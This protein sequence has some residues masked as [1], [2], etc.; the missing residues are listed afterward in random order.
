MALRTEWGPA[1]ELPPHRFTT[2]E[3][4]RMHEAGVLDEDDRVE[5][6]E[7][8]VLAMS[9]IGSRHARCTV[10]LDDG[11]RESLPRGAYTIRVRMPISI[12][13]YDEPE[14]DVAVVWRREDLYED[15]HPG[16]DDTLL[17]VEVSDVTYRRDR[18]TKL[19]RY[20]SAGIPE[21]WIADLGGDGERRG[22]GVERH[23][24]PDPASG[25]YRTSVRL[26]RGE[27]VESVALTGLSFP[28]SHILGRR[29]PPSPG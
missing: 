28:V 13:P 11:L 15:A 27:R 7:G 10:Y 16:A 29:R 4:H 17:V 23:T 20:A 14:P 22:E 26:V 25:A 21:V 5:L 8:K 24:D 3:Y 2:D 6:I 9:A 12:P 19:A 18:Y 1:A